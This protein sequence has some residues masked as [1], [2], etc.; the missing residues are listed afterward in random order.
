MVT[1]VQGEKHTASE[2]LA[3]N[4][5]VLLPVGWQALYS[6]VNREMSQLQRRIP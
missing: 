2:D 5:S 1:V 6:V 3:T 4:G